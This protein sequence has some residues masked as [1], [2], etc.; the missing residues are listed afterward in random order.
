MAIV[1]RILWPEV[2]PE[3]YD[4]I[5]EVADWEA[6]RAPGGRLHIAW[7][8]D[9]L[10]VWDVWDDAADFEHFVENHLNPGVAQVGL[11]GE[12]QVTMS[13]CHAW[14]VEHVIG[15]QVLIEVG[16]MPEAGAYDALGA[17]I[18][19]T[20]HAPKGAIAHIAAAEA[21]GSLTTL[22]AWRSAQASVNFAMDRVRPAAERLGIP[23]SIDGN[24]PP[25]SMVHALFAP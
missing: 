6:L 20:R 10:R 25:M 22:S 11:P 17:E 24:P 14:Q 21:D 23:L 19:W 3:G 9:G 8:D 16:Q 15:G 1:M 13:P 5:R 7:F 4:Q 18:G 2:T 12:P